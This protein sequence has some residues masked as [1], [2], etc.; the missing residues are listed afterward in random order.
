ME[1]EKLLLEI[2]LLLPILVFRKSEKNFYLQKS[3]Y[4]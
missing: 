1:L 3:E 4:F 2:G